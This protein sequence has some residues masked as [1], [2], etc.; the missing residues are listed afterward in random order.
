MKSIDQELIKKAELHLAF[1]E[2]KFAEIIRL[3]GPCTLV[4]KKFEPFPALISA[5]VSQQISAKAANSIKS[6][7]FVALD[8]PVS[9][10]PLTVARFSVN[11][12]QQYGLS[13]AKAQC[14]ITIAKAIIDESLNIDRLIHLE[15]EK[16]VETLTCY[17]GIG[18]WTV[19]MFLI[20][21]LL[22][23]NV[24]SLGDGGLPRA[25]Q[26]LYDLPKKPSQSELISFFDSW[27]PYRT[28]ASWYLWRV[29]D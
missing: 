2:P 7:L 4:H 28:I 14:L 24:L 16:I 20:F 6:R 10:W 11:E 21:G 23:P 15:D 8:E 29:L 17:K 27:Q 26:R 9:H 1:V 3:H 19:E 5:I 12:L 22:R 13:A 25:V 18:R